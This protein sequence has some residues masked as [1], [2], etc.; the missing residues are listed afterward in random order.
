LARYNVVAHQ[1]RP[2]FAKSCLA[3]VHVR[4]ITQIELN[5]KMSLVRR[6]MCSIIHV[7]DAFRS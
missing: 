7:E 2:V 4:K 5:L 3:L 1:V 6:R